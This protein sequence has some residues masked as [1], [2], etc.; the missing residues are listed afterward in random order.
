MG[1]RQPHRALE[2]PRFIFQA[3]G[4]S[5]ADDAV[6]ALRRRTGGLRRFSGRLRRAFDRFGDRQDLAGDPPR[7]AR[8]RRRGQKLHRAERRVCYLRGRPAASR[9]RGG[10]R[11]PLEVFRGLGGLGAVLS[12]RHFFHRHK[13]HQPGRDPCL[14]FSFMRCW[15]FRWKRFGRRRGDGRGDRRGAV[16]RVAVLARPRQRP[17][18]G[19]GEISRPR[20]SGPRPASA[21]CSGPNRFALF[22]AR[23]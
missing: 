5:A 9:G 21:S 12:R 23:R 14:A 2:R 7:I 1:G 20:I 3:A 8:Q 13:P 19:I 17:L 11:A 10:A 16:E 4:D 22:K 18:A 15:H 6:P